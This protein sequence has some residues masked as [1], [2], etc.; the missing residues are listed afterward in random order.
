MWFPNYASAEICKLSKCDTEIN[1][2]LK[3]TFPIFD[4]FQLLMLLTI[5]YS[6][7]VMHI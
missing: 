6:M 3:D 1:T 7:H 5:S 4:I 2:N